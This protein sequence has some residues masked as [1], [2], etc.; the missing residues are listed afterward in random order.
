MIA[1]NNLP[2]NWGNRLYCDI[3]QFGVSSEKDAKM[4]IIITLTTVITI[5]LAFYAANAAATDEVYR[6]VDENGVVHF[7]NQPPANTE[8]EQLEFDNRPTTGDQASPYSTLTIDEPA[9]E[10]PEP[11]RAQ[12]LR[13]ERAKKR[14]QRIEDQEITEAA[15]TQR[16][17]FVEEM[18]PST[19]VMVKYHDTGE[20]V[21]L[22][23]NKRLEILDE[24]KSF[25]AKNC[26]N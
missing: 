8:A 13:D 4:R 6:W 5:S 16:R 23:D 2:V 1:R 22:D 25:I 17:K 9:G 19:R 10:P 15:C 18:E 21:R 7:Q 12:Q 3:K 14:L 26:D 24:A 11:N 20:V